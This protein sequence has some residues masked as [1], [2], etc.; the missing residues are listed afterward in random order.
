MQPGRKCWLVLGGSGFLGV[1]VVRAAAAAGAEVVRASRRPRDPG[2]SGAARAEPCD[3]EEAGAV[4]Q[5]LERLRPEVV[6][7]CAALSR[8][9]DCEREPLRARRLNEEA[10]AELAVA[11]AGHGVRLVHLSTDLVFDGEPPRP[12]GYREED[13]AHPLSVYGATKLAGESAVLEAFPGALV[14]R[15]PLLFGPSGGR[16]LG[17]SDSL[18]AAVARGDTATLF[19]DELR[20]P[21]DAREAAA[22]LVEL[23]AGEASGRLHLA[24]PERLSRHALGELV[25]R[26]A[27]L[28]PAVTCR[29]VRPTSQRDLELTPPRPRDVSLDAG[30]ARELLGA[31]LSP[32]WRALGLSGPGAG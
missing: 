31:P 17:A 5:L 30:R 7:N 18:L 22:A 25:L 23:A 26:A 10:P 19:V 16:G 14:A 15:L 32:P 6:V 27:G 13:E 29:L 1:H 11:C 9:G 24:G 8:G 12:A 28:D 3:L 20:T 21:L 2:G 4:E